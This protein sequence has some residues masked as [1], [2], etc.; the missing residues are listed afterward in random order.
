LKATNEAPARL[1]HEF[2]YGLWLH[3]AVGGMGRATI[4]GRSPIA[5]VRVHILGAKSTAKPA[6]PLTVD[7]QLLKDDLLTN[8]SLGG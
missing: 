3:A 1:E 7:E 2:D 5:A 4:D 6:T 8:D